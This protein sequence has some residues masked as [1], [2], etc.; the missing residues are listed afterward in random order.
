MPWWGARSHNLHLPETK[1]TLSLDQRK[2]QYKVNF[3]SRSFNLYVC[4]YV[5]LKTGETLSLINVS[6]LFNVSYRLMSVGVHLLN[7]QAYQNPRSLRTEWVVWRVLICLSYSVVER[8]S[9]R[10]GVSE[11]SRFSKPSG[12]PVSVRT[13]V[14]GEEENTGGVPSEPPSRI[15]CH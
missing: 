9:R 2:E 12:T 3:V 8:K 15:I 4:V 13:F 7:K 6:L 1:R 11:S 10:G 14:T 5:C